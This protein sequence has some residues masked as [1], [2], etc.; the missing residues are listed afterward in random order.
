MLE[1]AFILEILKLM[2]YWANLDWHDRQAS[3]HYD[4]SFS[5][6]ISLVANIICSI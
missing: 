2:I 4:S 3:S 6:N 1:L 5:I